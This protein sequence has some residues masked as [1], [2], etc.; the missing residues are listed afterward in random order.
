MDE[1]K[2]KN[3]KV[4]NAKGKVTIAKKVIRAPPRRQPWIRSCATTPLCL[5]EC[6]LGDTALQLMIVLARA[7]QLRPVNRR[8]SNEL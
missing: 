8:K 4:E 5:T 2:T 6:R 3:Y 7:P 1:M